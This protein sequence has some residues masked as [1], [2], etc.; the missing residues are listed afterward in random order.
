MDTVAAGDWR[1][2][3][4]ADLRA[5]VSDMEKVSRKVED[6]V[7]QHQ[8]YNG[9]SGVSWR[10]VVGVLLAGFCATG[11]WAWSTTAQRVLDLEREASANRERIVRVE[12]TSITQKDQM[13]RIEAKIDSLLTIRGR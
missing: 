5:A 2:V 13:D 4:V 3:A 1:G 6:V 8:R 10:W 9:N 12:T 11:G 7:P